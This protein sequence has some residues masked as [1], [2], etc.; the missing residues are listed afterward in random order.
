[1]IVYMILNEAT[2]MSYV[3]RTTSTLEDRWAGHV[4]AAERGSNLPFH[5]AIREWGTE[6][7]TRVILQHCSTEKEL[8]IA[9]GNWIDYLCTREPAVGYNVAYV[10]S[11]LSDASRWVDRM[12]LRD[13]R[14]GARSASNPRSARPR[15]EMT[16][17]QIQFFRECGRRG[18][19]PRSEMTEEE[20]ERYREWGKKGAR[21]A[22]QKRLGMF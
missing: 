22:K 10:P 12:S 2:E 7:W 17:E 21:R 15:S 8:K 13:A 4:N 11:A 19:K 5:V 16:E 6:V 18:A 14:N 9:E 3:G 1:M 20:R